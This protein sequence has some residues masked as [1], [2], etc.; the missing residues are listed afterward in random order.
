VAAFAQSFAQPCPEVLDLQKLYE[1]SRVAELCTHAETLGPEFWLKA[2][3][4]RRY[5]VRDSVVVLKG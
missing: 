4:C 1:M 2:A 3:P 5:H